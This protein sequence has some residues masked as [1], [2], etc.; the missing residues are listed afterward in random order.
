MTRKFTY[1]FAAFLLSIGIFVSCSKSGPE[2]NPDPCAGKTIVINGVATPTSSSTTSNGTITVTASGSSGF[3]YN[4]NGGAYQA[5]GAFTGLAAGSYTIGAKDAAGCAK[6][7]SFTVTATPCPTITVNATTTATSGAGATDGSISATASGSTGY[8]FSLN[9]GAFQASGNFTGLAAGAYTV[10]AKDQNGCTGSGSFVVADPSCPTI[11]ITQVITPSASPNVNTGS[12]AATAS[13]GASPYTYSIDGG[14]TF[15]GSGTFN[16]LAAG[17]YT[18]IA[19]DANNC[20]G[21]SGTLTVTANPCPAITISN[22]IT[23]SD[24]CTNNTGTIT[25]NASGSTGFTYKLNSGSFQASN[26]FNS[27]PTGA[28]TIQVRDVNACVSS[29]NATV[30]QAAA[31]TR[32]SDVK[33]ILSANCALSGCHSGPTPQNGINFNDDCTIVTQSA[34]I[35]SRAVDGN[36]SFMPP[37]GPQ[38][39]TADK[40]KIVD[41]INAGGQ[42]SNN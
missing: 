9:G 15:Q 14:T 37:S 1:I 39:S 6:T 8:T 17:N 34:R 36:P 21:S 31:G 2:Q 35:R 25:V 3:T 4:I 18:I 33:A 38:L 42:H 11:T 19:K 5:T 13:G 40:Q 24:K 10:T 41:W 30:P 32:F 29:S 28:A 16:A 12:I 7:Q 26:V 27:L 22:N 20:Q 23:G